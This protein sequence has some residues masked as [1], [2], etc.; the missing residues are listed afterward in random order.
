M[1]LIFLVTSGSSVTRSSSV[2]PGGSQLVLATDGVALP[3]G[4]VAAAGTLDAAPSVPPSFALGFFFFF[5]FWPDLGAGSK[6]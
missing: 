3:V 1:F 2:I 5:L 4:A 6:K